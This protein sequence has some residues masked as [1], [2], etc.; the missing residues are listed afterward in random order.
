MAFFDPSDILER[1]RIE[2]KRYLESKVAETLA[3][4][5]SKPGA[6]LKRA[7]HGTYKLS[8][9][10]EK[11]AILE[12][13]RQSRQARIL[14]VR[15]QEMLHAAEC[16]GEFRQRKKRDKQKLLQVLKAIIAEQKAKEAEES[17]LWGTLRF[18]KA[19]QEENARKLDVL[20]EQRLAKG[21]RKVL[22]ETAAVDRRRARTHASYAKSEAREEKKLATNEEEPEKYLRIDFN[23]DDIRRN[24]IQSRLPG[25]PNDYKDTYFHSRFSMLKDRS[26]FSRR[27]DY[28]DQIQHE[29]EVDAWK[30][31]EAQMKNVEMEKERK[32]ELEEIWRR[33]KA[34]RGHAAAAKLQKIASLEKELAV[35][36]EEEQERKRQLEVIEE[37]TRAIHSPVYK[38]DSWRRLQPSNSSAS[39]GYQFP[40]HFSKAHV[41]L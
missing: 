36:L 24:F 6:N 27:S 15:A 2:R 7:E 37:L 22:S 9:D 39:K 18:H 33:R 40:I 3:F 16:V 31:A 14:Q 38:P 28:A 29:A 25:T 11:Q 5:P 12:Y 4:K 8:P 19:M 41:I 30:A 10:E 26:N 20:Q 21:R 23:K 13:Q 34:E 35:E 32:A 17:K 1:Q